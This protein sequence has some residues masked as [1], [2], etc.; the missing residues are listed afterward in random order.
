M[1][2]L[3]TS[4]VPTAA[5]ENQLPTSIQFIIEHLQHQHIMTPAE[6][7][8]LVLSANVQA[9]DLLPWADYDH[10]VQDSYGRRMIHKGPHFEVMVMSWLP[11]D[12]SAIHDHGHTQWGAVQVFGP[13]EHATFAVQDG[14]L[15]TTAR[16]NFSPGDVVGI[17]HGMTHQ[18][19]NATDEPFVSLHVYGLDEAV[20]SVTGN[21]KVYELREGAILRVD[22]G[23]FLALPESEVLRREPCPPADEPTQQRYLQDL[24]NRLEKM[25]SAGLPGADEQW[26]E[27]RAML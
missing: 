10:P 27:V 3:A 4:S 20:E 1:S 2:N 11:G 17:N 14:L 25:A 22:G 13:A 18:M 26:K 19:G 24:A 15:R 23:V 9:E 6:M 12:F 5:G 16:F 7:R 21:A 8:S